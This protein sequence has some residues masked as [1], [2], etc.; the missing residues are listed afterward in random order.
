M[1]TYEER[2]VWGTGDGHGLRVHRY[3]STAWVG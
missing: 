3:G 1:P 2:L